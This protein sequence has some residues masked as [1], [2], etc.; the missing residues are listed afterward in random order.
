MQYYKRQGHCEAMETKEREEFV[1]IKNIGITVG[2]HKL[3]FLNCCLA[4]ST[5]APVDLYGHRDLLIKS[6][7]QGR[8]VAMQMHGHFHALA[9]K[10]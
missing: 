6:D 9:V 8:V 4:A 5:L 2:D 1:Q 3:F 10:G 7:C